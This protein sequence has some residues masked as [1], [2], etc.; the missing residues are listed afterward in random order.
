MLELT[1]QL[2]SHN[3]V[4][5]AALEEGEEVNLLGGLVQVFSQACA[6]PRLQMKKTFANR[7]HNCTECGYENDRNAASA[8]M[9]L[10]WACGT[11][12]KLRKEKIKK[13]SGQELSEAA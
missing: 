3:N 4:W 10:K 6:K 9:V 5:N 12:P 2:H 1:R 11:L 13:L 8:L 7:H